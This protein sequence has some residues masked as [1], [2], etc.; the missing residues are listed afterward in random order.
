M[1]TSLTG[2]QASPIKED[3]HGVLRIGGTRVSLDSIVCAYQ[4]G[5]TAEQIADDFPTLD[6]ADI[7]VAIGL[8]LRH[9]NEVADYLIAQEQRAEEVRRQIA[10]IV[11]QGNIRQRFLARRATKGRRSFGELVG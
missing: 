3:E 4:N 11:A 9:R 10:P 2:V 5:A 8:Y 1:A 7:H 6:L